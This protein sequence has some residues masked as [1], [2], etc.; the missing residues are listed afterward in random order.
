MKN[1]K[2]TYAVTWFGRNESEE[3]L[4]VLLKE[5]RPLLSAFTWHFCNMD[6]DIESLGCLAFVKWKAKMIHLRFNFLV[7]EDGRCHHKRST[8]RCNDFTNSA[9]QT[10]QQLQTSKISGS[11]RRRQSCVDC[12]RLRYSPS[13]VS[14]EN[15]KVLPLKTHQTRCN[16]FPYE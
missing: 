15:Q 5:G 11:F 14:S 6:C 8:A 2:C 10:Q 7:V 12:Q 1:S 4:I 13:A 3:I 9:G 16:S